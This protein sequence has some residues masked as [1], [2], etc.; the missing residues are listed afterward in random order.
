MR[1]EGFPGNKQMHDFRGPFNNHIDTAVSQDTLDRPINLTTGLQRFS[2]FISLTA[3]DLKGFV[4]N[5]PAFLCTKIFGHGC[6]KTNIFIFVV[7]HKG[8]QPGH[9]IHGKGR[10]GNLSKLQTDGFMFANSRAPLHTFFAPLT[11][12]VQAPLGNSG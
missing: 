11:Q 2:P 6:L 9:G 10:R 12:N 5:L 8:R 7:R 3:A 4:D 1:I